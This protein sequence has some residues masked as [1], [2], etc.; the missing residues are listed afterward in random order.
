[1]FLSG[2]R[3]CNIFVIYPIHGVNKDLNPV[4]LRKVKI[5]CNFGLFECNRLKALYSKL[6]YFVLKVFGCHKVTHLRS[7]FV[8]SVKN[9]QGSNL[10]IFILFGS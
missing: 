1:M 7:T 2:G 3:L 4:A 6:K 5:V 8:F 10:F 9:R